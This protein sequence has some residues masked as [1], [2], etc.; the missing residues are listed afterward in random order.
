MRA[1]RKTS[2]QEGVAEQDDDHVNLQQKM[3]VSKE[4]TNL[5]ERRLKEMQEIGEWRCDRAFL[6]STKN[7][8]C[9]FGVHPCGKRVPCD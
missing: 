1:A 7:G 5:L 9:N 2:T 6:F 4:M 3:A 8:L